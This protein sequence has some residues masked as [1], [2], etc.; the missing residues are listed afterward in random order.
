MASSTFDVIIIGAGISGINVGYHLRTQ[1]PNR[2][3]LI[4]EAR[5]N[6]GGT[7]DIFRYPGVRSD[8]DMYTFGFQWFPWNQA[9]PIG[10]G[11]E[12][13][14]YLEDAATM[15]EIRQHIRP[16][17]RVLSS[18]WNGR[19]WM[20]Q[21]Q[22]PRGIQHLYAQFTI[23]ATGY[24]DSQRPL[25]ATIRG[26]ENFQ[27]EIIH[28]QFWPENFDPVGKNIIVIGSG[29]TAVTLVPSLADIAQSVTLLQRSPTY[30]AAVPNEARRNMRWLGGLVPRAFVY[31]FRRLWSLVMSQLFYSFCRRFPNAARAILQAEVKTQLPPNIPLDPHFMPRYNPWEQRLCACPDGDFFKALKSTKARVATGIISQVDAHGIQ[32]ASG[33]RLDG[34]TIITA[35]GLRLQLLGGI[36][37]T[38][39]GRTFDAAASFV[40]NALMLEGLPNAMLIMG[41]VNAS[42]TLGADI[43]MRLTCRIMKHMWKNGYTSAVPVRAIEQD[44]PQRPVMD[45]EATY[46]KRAAQRLPR[47]STQRPWISRTGYFSDLYF[48]W[49]G[50]IED[51]LVFSP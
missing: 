3:F 30:L 46:V 44:F 43:S 22:S 11:E 10:K 18:D 50:S 15:S 45:L 23:F 35:T 37:I 5:D 38:I 51:G 49:L 39:H 12:I 26:L 16:S 36:P 8:S 6:I 24:Y 27:G 20:L 19:G 14:K 2:S 40:W 7:W 32:L 4:L 47:A 28:P 31:H 41:F 34:D 1:F 13:M 17:H 9:N 25:E 48:S 33:E 29:A 21:V 42:W